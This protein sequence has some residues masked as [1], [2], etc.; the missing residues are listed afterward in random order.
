M[1]AALRREG[2]EPG[3]DTRRAGD[4]VGAWLASPLAREIRSG[5]ASLRAEHP[6]LIE[7]AGATVRGSIDLLVTQP[8]Q[9]PL[10]VDYKTNRL[11]DQSPVQAAEEYETQQRLYA[12]AAARGLDA[13]RVRVAYVF[14]ERPGDPVIT[15]LGPSELA[16]AAAD[17]EEHIRGI[18]G[19]SFDVTPMPDWPLCHDCP[20]RARL[21]PA[22]ARP[23]RE[24]AKRI[25]A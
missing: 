1:A 21:C 19:G 14:L 2:L 20:A 9:P 24:E 10:L 22:P 4:L 15:E 11:G 25:A 8:H 18:A 12:L 17:I 7:L 6:F 3:S 23:H 13:D 16:A 5:P